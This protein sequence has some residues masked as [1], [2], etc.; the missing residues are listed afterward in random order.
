MKKKRRKR[1]ESFFQEGFPYWSVGS[2]SVH[3]LEGGKEACEEKGLKEACKSGKKVELRDEGKKR[4]LGGVNNFQW[5]RTPFQGRNGLQSGP[6][7]NR[8]FEKPLAI[9]EVTGSRQRFLKKSLRSNAAP[10]KESVI[11]F[12]GKKTEGLQKLAKLA[13]AKS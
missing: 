1:Q 7:Q 6:R 4:A 9:E 8:D 13:P 10:K 11:P 2:R 5:G 12:I 3:K